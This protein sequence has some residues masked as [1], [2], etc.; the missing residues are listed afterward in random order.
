MI[1]ERSELPVSTG[2]PGIPRIYDQCMAAR[3]EGDDD[4]AETYSEISRR[5]LA[6]LYLDPVVD[7]RIQEVCWRALYNGENYI[8]IGHE[9][10]YRPVGPEGVLTLIRYGAEVIKE[11]MDIIFHGT[12][13]EKEEIEDIANDLRRGWRAENRRQAAERA[14]VEKEAARR[15][16]IKRNMEKGRA[17]A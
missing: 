12:E 13:E 17:T 1:K 6:M 2:I 11:R 9:K 7:R 14:K 5:F 3:A 15:A 4:E 8:N 16:A 10:Q